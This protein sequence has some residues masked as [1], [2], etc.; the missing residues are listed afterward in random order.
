[1]LSAIA[2]SFCS[3]AGVIAS[4]ASRLSAAARRY[5]VERSAVAA[6]MARIEP[7]MGAGAPTRAPI[8]RDQLAQRR[9]PVTDRV[10]EISERQ[11]ENA[12][13]RARDP[14]IEHV[15]LARERH[16]ALQDQLGAAR[17]ALEIVPERAGV[18]DQADAEA[19]AAD[20]GLGNHGKFQVGIGE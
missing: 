5:A 15:G 11:S 7:E 18:G 13:A 8:A 16:V 17:K 14:R 4:R 1:M 10:R 20:V 2:T 9:G 6:E 19:A 3:S 12:S